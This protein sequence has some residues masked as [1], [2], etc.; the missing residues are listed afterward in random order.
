VGFINRFG[1]IRMLQASLGLA[2]LGVVCVASGYISLIIIGA[3]L[4]GFSY[5]PANPTSSRLLVRYVPRTLQ[6]FYFSVKQTSVP[7]AGALAG[8]ALPVI[9]VFAGW[10]VACLICAVACIGLIVVASLWQ[11]K[12]DTD[13]D[14]TASLSAAIGFRAIAL[15]LCQSKLRRLALSCTA[16][17]SLQFVYTSFFVAIVTEQAGLSLMVAGAALSAAMAMSAGTRL[18]W[19]W[20]ADLFSGNTI[21]GLLGIGMGILFFTLYFVDISWSVALIFSLSITIGITAVSWNGIFLSEVARVAP[22]DKITEATAG[23]MVFMFSGGL[24]APATFSLLEYLTGDYLTGFLI[25][26]TLAILGGLTI[27]RQSTTSNH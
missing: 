15:V 9:T 26:T 2:T 19:G 23:S 13:R 7:V 18:F 24:L 17:A 1:G 3:V 6:N 20:I 25:V 27:L 14:P 5:G 12:L 11:R 22:V 10:R 16:F 21:L 4:I 8:F